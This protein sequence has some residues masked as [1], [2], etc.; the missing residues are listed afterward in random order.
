MLHPYA[1][2]PRIAVSGVAVM[3]VLLGVVFAPVS[4]AKRGDG[5]DV[6]IGKALFKRTWV[7]APSSTR[8]T[9]GLGPLFNARSCAQCHSAATAGRL[10]TDDD[11]H[12]ADRGGVVRL[13][14]PLGGGDARYGAQVQTRAVPGL[15]AEASV[16]VTWAD[17]R[18]T[19]DDGT[20]VN[21]RRPVVALDRPILGPLADNVEATLLLA[22]SLRVAA[23]ISRVDGQALSDMR[24]DGV[25][26]GRLSRD[27]TGRARLFGH[28]ATETDLERMTSV[29]FLR[30]LGL[31]TKNQPNSAGDCTAAQRS[32]QSAPQGA[33]G[34]EV[35]IGPE[36]TGAVATYLAS[37]SGVELDQPAEPKGREVFTKLGCA[38]CHQPA[39]PGYNGQGITLYSD[40][41]LHDMGEGLAGLT[42]AGGQSRGE[43][44]TAPLIGSGQRL[45]AGSTLLHDGRARTLSEAVLWHGGEAAT[46][47]SA[48]KALSKDDRSALERF[49][50]SR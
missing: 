41:R 30:D 34:G 18:E 20:N 40:L 6:A 3:F 47:R 39:M 27:D 25:R 35:E 45:M 13:S 24:D 10:E 36:I 14:T 37:L 11:G 22:P 26:Q 29:A 44:R 9:D 31:S 46:V 8:T 19:L 2:S 23:R 21:L 12:L 16:R 17:T 38:S 42:E 4:A 1:I 32:C 33:A 28:K 5:L 48:Y 49:I 7:P 50:F 43:W 15:D